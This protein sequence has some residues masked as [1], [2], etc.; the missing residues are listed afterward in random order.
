MAE[1][2]SELFKGRLDGVMSEED[3]ERLAGGLD[4]RWFAVEA[5]SG[6]VM[7]LSG[8]EA[9]ERL[10]GLRDEV[11]ARNMLSAKFPYT[12]VHTPSAPKMIKT[13]DPLKCGSGCSTSSP[14]PWWVFSAVRPAPEEI[15]RLLPAPARKKGLAARLLGR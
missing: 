5:G 12:Y 9:G 10:L 2:F 14:D 8:A 13:Y 7:E 6:A 4:G 11:R 15:E 3:Y 1:T